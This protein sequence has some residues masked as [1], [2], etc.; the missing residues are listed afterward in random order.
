VH[1]TVLDILDQSVELIV[2]MTVIDRQRMVKRR[3]KARSEREEE[4]VVL[5]LCLL[6][7]VDDAARRVEP[8]EAVFDEVC[9]D[10]TGDLLQRVSLGTP[11][12]KWLEDAH[13]P[14]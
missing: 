13:R 3:A 8:F 11:A 10:V 14:V 7:G 9:I 2:E 1:V 4:R 6:L 12:R 5:D